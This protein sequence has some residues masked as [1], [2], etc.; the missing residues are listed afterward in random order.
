MKA[1]TIAIVS[2][3]LITM[4]ELATLTVDGTKIPIRKIKSTTQSKRMQYFT[5]LPNGQRNST[6]VELSNYYDLQYIGTLGVGSPPQYFQVIFDTGS[7]DIWFPGND[8]TS[9]RNGEKFFKPKLSSTYQAAYDSD[10]KAATFAIQY[11]SGYVNG[12]DAY[13]TVVVPSTT[14]SDG[15]DLVIPKIKIGVVDAEDSDISSD[16]E[17][18]G[19][20][21]LG[22]NSLSTVTSPSFIE[23]VFGAGTSYYDQKLFSMYLGSDPHDVQNPSFLMLGGYD[24]SAVGSNAQVFYTPL[25]RFDGVLAYWTVSLLGFKVSAK[26]A[27][28]TL[29]LSFCETGCVGIVDSGTSGLAVPH[30][31]YDDILSVLTHGLHCDEDSLCNGVTAADFPTLKIYLDPGHEFLLQPADYLECGGRQCMLLLMDSGADIWILGDSFMHAYYTIFDVENER[32]GFVCDGACEGSPLT[33]TADFSESGGNEITSS[34]AFAILFIVAMALMIALLTARMWDSFFKRLSN[35]SSGNNNYSSSSSARSSS[36]AAK[37]SRDDARFRQRDYGSFMDDDDAAAA[38]GEHLDDASDEDGEFSAL[39]DK[40]RRRDGLSAHYHYGNIYNPADT[41][42]ADNNTFYAGNV[43]H[44]VTAEKLLIAGT[45]SCDSSNRRD[46]HSTLPAVESNHSSII[47][48]VT[49]AIAS[50]TTVTTGTASYLS[51][52]I[53]PII[54]SLSDSDTVADSTTAAAADRLYEEL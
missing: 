40:Q 13:E 17:M 18:E 6:Y 46:S 44:S 20:C 12:I 14:G 15:T 26:A 25:Q 5:R 2:T 50:T 24:L 53:V 8:C 19:I 7:S 45:A 22:F 32:I 27:G 47:T 16:S 31:M 38:V 33:L 1:D 48:G 29:S 21:G 52:P 30:S 49:P 51:H 9:C 28:V 34:P 42:D 39:L 37:T 35:S 36:K 43:R 11:G 10:G 4:L 54:E 41:T 23:T 3:V